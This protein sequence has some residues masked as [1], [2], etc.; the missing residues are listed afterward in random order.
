MRSSNTR[1]MI[2]AM[3]AAMAFGSVGLVK[4][5]RQEGWGEGEPEPISDQPTPTKVEH[6][7]HLDGR[8]KKLTEADCR[9]MDA[10]E[11]KRERKRQKRRQQLSQT[12][13]EK[14]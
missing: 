7:R 2:G 14:P 13:R 4:I 5:D 1:M 10:A 11:E 9:A 12:E 3:G 6:P 8:P